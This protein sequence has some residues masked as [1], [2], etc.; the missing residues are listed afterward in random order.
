MLEGAIDKAGE[1]A[2]DIKE[3]AGDVLEEAIDKASEAAAA[4]KEKVGELFGGKKE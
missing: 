4:I 2:A 3:K 1:V